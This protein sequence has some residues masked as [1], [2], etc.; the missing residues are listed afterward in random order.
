MTFASKKI[1]S[2]RK[3]KVF[4]FRPIVLILGTIGVALTIYIGYKSSISDRKLFSISLLALF[5]GLLF[6]CFRI[7]GNYK[8]VI[9][10]FIGAYFLSLIN[11]M[12]SIIGPNDY[13]EKYIERWPYIFVLIF[14]LGFAIFNTDKVTAK[15][16]EGIS[17][18]LSISLL[19]WTLDYDFNT[20]NTWFE[21]VF[22]IIGFSFILFSL[23][24][25]FTYLKLTANMRLALSIWS[26]IIMF[27]FAADNIFRVFSSGD[28][29]SS[30]YLSQS[31]Y[32]G[33][34]YF[35]LGVSAIY[36]VQNYLLMASFLPRKNE[37]YQNDLKI[38][39]KQHI[40]RFSDQ[41]VLI[42]QSLFCILYAVTL[43]GLNYTYQVLPRHTMIWFVFITFPLILQLPEIISEKK[44]L[45][46]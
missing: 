2:N 41:Q 15:L 1:K 46:E 21:I 43:F 27:A 24:N 30:K 39:K 13:F 12:P 6:E 11:F 4:D 31:I 29:E 7:S 26:T 22:L 33:I 25:A 34:Q 32:I 42:S 10:I 36:I 35:F 38:I 40:D 17:L 16:T 28:I 44:Y 45:Y 14:A 37:N 8:K 3:L 23:L 18:L 19:Y 20:Y 5:A 9:L